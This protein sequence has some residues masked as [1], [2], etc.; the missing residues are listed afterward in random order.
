MTSTWTFIVRDLDDFKKRGLSA[1]YTFITKPN[2]INPYT[3]KTV[4]D[5][6][7]EGY[8]VLSEEEFDSILQKQ[9]D[10]LC[11]DWKEETEEQYNDSLNVL[12]P[13]KWYDGGFYVSEAYTS[14]IYSYHQK[15]NGRFYSSLQRSSTPRAEIIESLK[16]Y[17]E[18]NEMKGE[19][20]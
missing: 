18:T 7:A 2:G 19:S 9:E 14:N 20:K 16:R 3:G 11:G 12:P 13:L 4:D 6:L 17:I 1:W 10:S 8:T 15:W 5:Y